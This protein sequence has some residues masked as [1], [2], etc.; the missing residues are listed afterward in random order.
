MSKPVL[1]M[2]ST[3]D[4]SLIVVS[5][6][7]GVGEVAAVK[8]ACLGK[9]VRWFV[10][11]N[12]AGSSVT[13]APQ[14]LQEISDAS[15]AL[16]LAGAGVE[17]LQ[18]GG[19]AVLAVSEWCASANGIICSYDGCGLDQGFKAAVRLVAKEAS[20]GVKGTRVAII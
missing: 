20:V 15:G 7:G 10:V 8:A 16:S 18:A 12:E 3:S 13:L 14:T 19:D 2:A 1:Q 11:S 6:P 4:K 17:D 5:P 9:T